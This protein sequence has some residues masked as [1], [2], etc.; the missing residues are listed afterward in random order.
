METILGLTI[1]VFVDDICQLA[2]MV[3]DWTRIFTRL[4][5]EGLFVFLFLFALSKFVPV[6]PVW[7]VDMNNKLAS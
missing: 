5:Q 2:D 7:G 1:F 3:T 6:W 4:Y